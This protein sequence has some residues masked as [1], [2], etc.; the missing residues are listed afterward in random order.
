MKAGA[1][2]RSFEQSEHPRRPAS[3]SS[4]PFR[5]QSSGRLTNCTSALRVA[6][7]LAIP[8]RAQLT[9]SSVC[10]FVS[11][12]MKTLRSFHAIRPRSVIGPFKSIRSPRGPLDLPTL[13]R[14][15]QTPAIATG[16]NRGRSAS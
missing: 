14:Q 1:G 9:L 15:L 5:P 7:S 8:W 10:T 4:T 11:N 13:P 2:H 3:K 16:M 12:T 6:S